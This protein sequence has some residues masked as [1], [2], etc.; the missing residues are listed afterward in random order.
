MCGIFGCIGNPLER[1]ATRRVLAVLRHRGPDADGVHADTHVTLVH[2]RLRILDLTPA[3]SQPMANEDKSVWVTFNGEVY[4]FRELRE[5]LTA[6]GHR[7]RSSGDTEV[8]LRGYE[9]WGDGLVERLDGMFAFGVWDARRRHLLLA[10]DRMGKKPLFFAQHGGSLWFASELK[11]LFAAGVPL[12]PSAQGI[13][14]YLAYGYAPPPGT[15][16][17]GIEQLPPAHRLTLDWNG[18]PKIERY[19]SLDFTP[20]LASISEEEAAERVRTLTTEAVRRRLVADVPVGAFLSGGIDSSIVVGTMA[21]LGRR[22]RTFAIGFL[23]DPRYDETRYARLAARHF[24]T[25]HH[26]FMVEP[27]D[28]GLTERL[29]WHHDGPFG[30]SSAIPTYVVSRLTRQHVTVALSGDGGDE[31]FAGYVRFWAGTLAE[32][33][34]PVLRRLGHWAARGLPDGMPERSALGRM[35]R[36]LRAADLPLSDRLVAWNSYFAFTLDEVLQPDVLRSVSPRNILAFA[37]D[38]F[39][40][41]KLSP[42]ALSLQHNFH[43]YL[44]YDLMV[45]VDRMSMAHSLETRSPFL[46]T[47]MVE[48]AASLPDHFKLSGRTTKHILRRAFQ[49]MLPATI[50]QRGKMGFGVPLASWF[51]RELYSFLCD[52]VA[53]STS[54]IAEYVRP[55]YVQQLVTQHVSGSSDCSHQLWALLTMEI[56]LKNL[57][58]LARPIDEPVA[59]QVA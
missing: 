25:D 15:L 38:H 13:A 47:A 39:T 41:R 14:G 16:Y 28:F 48:F 54:R 51:R 37:R 8:L 18:T 31:L 40:D 56:W 10:R 58:A 44:P 19:W 34:P 36:F 30:D 17:E 33:V 12:V 2:T 5:E 24:E 23:G 50:T 52:Q 3:A 43:T 1:E 32:R 20:K 42:L 55:A 21:A 6:A 27:E 29:I 26:E 9:E 35:R 22:V 45:K 7:F 53:S 4:N 57:S 49:N 46:D 11:A 59:S